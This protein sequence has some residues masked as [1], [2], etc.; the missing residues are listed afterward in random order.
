MTR[1][2]RLTLAAVALLLPLLALGGVVLKNERDIASARTWR[3]EITGYDP[4]D[5]LQGHYLNF[6]F[7]WG[8]SPGNGVC[9]AGED[10]CLCLDARPAS[11]VPAASHAICAAATHCATTL[12]LP[13]R[14]ACANGAQ[15]C[16]RDEEAF[17]PE[18]VQRYFVPEA[19]AEQLNALLANRRHTLSVD[20]K[21][22]TSGRHIFGDLYVD[23][24]EWRDYLRAHP[25]AGASQP[26]QSHVEHRWRMKISEARLYGDYL[27]FKLNWGAPTTR[28]ACPDANSC[29][30]LCLTERAGTSQPGVENRTCGAGDQCLETLILP[31]VDGAKHT[32]RGF[33]PNGPQ[34][35]PMSTEETELLAP[36]LS[37]PPK[38]FS[39]DVLTRGWSGPPE[40]GDLYV[41]GVEWREWRRRRLEGRKQKSVPG[42]V[43]K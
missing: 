14:A 13:K 1:R 9:G 3:V 29:C 21:V 17:D 16:A 30:A 33:D 4:R 27:V 25:D 39:I 41:D 19:S 2:H 10:C 23:D 28:R 7:D 8:P 40:Y 35:Y 32:D 11:T 22:A 24:V 15:S 12:S 31:A 38:D 6:R 20:L 34:R 5:L 37:G 43:D 42:D 18:G 36:I 26:T